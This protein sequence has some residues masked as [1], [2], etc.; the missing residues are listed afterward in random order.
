MLPM[1]LS[2]TA[3]GARVAQILSPSGGAFVP[4]DQSAAAS[5]TDTDSNNYWAS[6][7][8]SPTA[9]AS[10]ASE[11]K[12]TVPGVLTTNMQ[13]SKEFNNNCGH[14][15]SDDTGRPSGFCLRSPQ[16]PLP[17]ECADYHTDVQLLRNGSFTRG[18][19]ISWSGRINATYMKELVDK[20]RH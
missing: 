9:L 5:S 6:Q 1:D 8:A 11:A 16:Q 3:N 12:I 17:M 14:P 7:K 20:R 19:S 4:C 2:G 15:S 13:D 18:E 10:K